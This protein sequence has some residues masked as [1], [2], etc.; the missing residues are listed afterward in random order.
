MKHAIFLII[1][2]P[3][4]ALAAPK[5]TYVGEGRYQCSGSA[6]ECQSTERNNTD[7]EHQ[8]RQ[9]RQAEDQQRKQREMSCDRNR[10]IFCQGYKR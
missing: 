3:L 7:R 1:L 4:M 5:V 8:K 2:M 6:R 10:D 9:E